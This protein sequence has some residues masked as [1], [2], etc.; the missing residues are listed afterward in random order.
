MDSEVVGDEVPEYEHPVVRTHPET[1]RKGLYINP[2]FT[3]RFAGWTKKESRPLLEYLFDVA[4][5]EVYTCRFRWRP[6]LHRHVGQSLR[7]ALRA[8]RL[9]WSAPPHAPG[10]RQRRS[11]PLIMRLSLAAI[12]VACILMSPV[13]AAQQSYKLPRA[14]DGHPELGGRVDQRQRRCGVRSAG[15]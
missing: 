5:R 8:E 1:G 7:L 13:A 6:R 14:P 12:M 15:G 11:G 4:R 9:S 2:A 3:L 10:H